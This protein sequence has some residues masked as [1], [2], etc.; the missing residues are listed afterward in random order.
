[1]Q[2]KFESQKT[3]SGSGSRKINEN[4]VGKDG[5][6]SNLNRGILCPK[7]PIIAFPVLARKS[8][9]IFD[10][11]KEDVKTIVGFDMIAG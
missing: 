6:K 7:L 2:V 8:E 5:Q 11:F 3:R 9:A 4:I 1:M 10:V